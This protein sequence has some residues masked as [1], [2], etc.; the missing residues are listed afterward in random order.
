M[1]FLELLAMELKKEGSYIAR[2]LSYRGAEFEGLACPLTEEDVAAYNTAADLW[3]RAAA[4]AREWGAFRGKLFYGALLRFFRLMCSAL[5][6]RSIVGAGRA[7]LARGECVVIGMQS[8]GEAGLSA[9]GVQAGDRC[10]ELRSSAK[11]T[12]LSYLRNHVASY[13]TAP[14]P[15]AR[16][17]SGGP[18]GRGADAPPL[19]ELYAAL[20]ADVEAAPLPPNPLDALIEAFGGPDA[21]AEMTG[22][23]LRIVRDV[24]A[25]RG[26]GGAGLPPFVVESRVDAGARSRIQSLADDAGGTGSTNVLE[27]RA[28]QAGHKLV[29]LLSDAAS[30]GI[31]LHAS[32]DAE[33]T[34]RRCHVRFFGCFYDER[35]WW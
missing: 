16:A 22:R 15:A 9:A 11:D 7:A 5:K 18:G 25:A 24:D 12:L 26:F 17:G 3:Q 27:A 31:S 29:A 2:S 6:V 19:A 28:F 35:G 14:V 34:R 32:V 8:T 4:I 23:K 33:N 30:T 13:A 1:S 10:G 20:V 21:V